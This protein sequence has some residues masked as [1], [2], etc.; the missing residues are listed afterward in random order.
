MVKPFW[1]NVSP[2][3]RSSPFFRFLSFFSP[4]TLAYFEPALKQ[5]L[6]DIFE[7]VVSAPEL[8]S[9]VEHLYYVWF[10]LLL[11]LLLTAL[12]NFVI[13][14]DSTQCSI[15]FLING[16]RPSYYIRRITAIHFVFFPWLSQ[17]NCRHPRFPILWRT[18]CNGQW[19]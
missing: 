8:P 13:D 14:F 15:I 3:L 18:D 1:Q 6:L 7:V 9:V 5:F 4:Q 19:V 2:L 17:N 11:Y 10:Q 16:F 12:T